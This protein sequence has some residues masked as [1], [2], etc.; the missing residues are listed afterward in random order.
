MHGRTS[1]TRANHKPNNDGD[2][3]GRIQEMQENIN[4]QLALFKGELTG[5]KGEENPPENQTKNTVFNIVF[6]G[7]FAFCMLIRLLVYYWYAN[8][9]MVQSTNIAIAIWESGW[10][11][12]PLEVQ[13]MMKMMILRSNKALGL[14]I[15]PFATMTLNSFLGVS[16][17]SLN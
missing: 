15:G 1:N 14:D 10:Y 13:Q 3:S 16:V 7:E 2:L 8:E 5:L 12:E 17:K 9:V 4:S 6:C 11:E